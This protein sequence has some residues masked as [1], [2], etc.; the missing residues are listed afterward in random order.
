MP[1]VS[2]TSLPTNVWQPHF[3]FEDTTSLKIKPYDSEKN[4]GKV[5]LS[6]QW[7]ALCG[8]GTDQ[9]KLAGGSSVTFRGT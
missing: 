1:L 2:L 3:S 8:H 7:S 4:D 5:F 9:T 6:A